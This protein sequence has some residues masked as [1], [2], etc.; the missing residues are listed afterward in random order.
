MS[1]SKFEVGEQVEVVDDQ[2]LYQ[3]HIVFIH[4]MDE[5]GIRR[6]RV[7]H[8]MPEG[9][10]FIHWNE[11]S[12]RTPEAS[13]ALQLDCAAVESDLRTALGCLREGNGKSAT[14]SAKRAYEAL[15]EFHKS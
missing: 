11:E 3:G 6:Y 1:R 13:Q 10:I 5:F 2:V 7:R 15:A 8:E 12:L 4:Q 14:E 9:P